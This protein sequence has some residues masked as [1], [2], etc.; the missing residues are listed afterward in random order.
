MI[1]S[2][3]IWILLD[4]ALKRHQVR[5]SPDFKQ[6]TEEQVPSHVRL[7]AF[8]RLEVTMNSRGNLSEN[9]WKLKDDRN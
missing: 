5:Y 4:F 9:W 7:L 1:P 6:M 8:Y 2:L 3:H